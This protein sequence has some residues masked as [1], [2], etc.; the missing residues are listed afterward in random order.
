MSKNNP[1]NTVSREREIVRTS[2]IGIAGNVFLVAFKA[3]VGL[4]SGSVAIVMDAVNN[5]SDALSSV[6]TIVGMKLAAKP[7]D[8]KHPFGYGRIEYL[9]SMIIAGLVLAAGVSSLVESVKKIFDPTEPEYSVPTLIII[10]VAI[11]VKIILG[12]YFQRKGKQV[13]SD[14]LA[15]SGKDAMFDSIISAATLVSAVVMLVWHISVDGYLGALISIVIVKSGIELLIEALN[16]I[17]GEREESELTRAIKQKIAAYDGVGGAYDL[18]LHNYGPEIKI[19]SVHIEIAD[20]LTAKEIAA[21]TRKIQQAIFAEYGVYLTIGIYAVDSSDSVQAQMR[22]KVTDVAKAVDGVLQIHGFYVDADLINF[23][24]VV[25]FEVKDPFALRDGLARQI[26]EL[27]PEYRVHISL[28]RD[29][30]D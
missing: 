21:L 15:A 8:K 23:D 1:E 26:Q 24:V 11:A 13:R 6:I 29:Y 20:T 4:I 30:S 14:S 9:S 16:R 25:D 7:A 12:I 22:E 5:L 18:T 17:I 2:I 3:A 27:Y 28:D 10:A 19:G